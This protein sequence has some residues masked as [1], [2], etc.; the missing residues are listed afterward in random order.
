MFSKNKY[1]E[2]NIGEPGHTIYSLVLSP[3]EKLLYLASD[4]KKIKIFDIKK[5]KI[6]GTDI[7]LNF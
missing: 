2:K 3:D 5:N 7:Q 6:I 4:H 1:K